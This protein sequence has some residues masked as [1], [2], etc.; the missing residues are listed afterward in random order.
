MAERRRYASTVRAEATRATRRRIL[1]AAKEQFLARGYVGTTLDAVAGAAEV[2]PQT[3]YNVVGGKAKLLKAVY[4]VTLAGDDE[5]VPLVGRP[6]FRRVHDATTAHEALAAYA[7]VGRLVWERVGPLVAVATAQAAAG[8]R[9]LREFVEVI[10]GER[11]TGVQ[12]LVRDLAGRFGLRPGLTVSRATDIVW[13]LFAPEMID[14]L[15]T[16]RGWT[17]PS[18]IEWV[19]ETAV[20]SL[21]DQDMP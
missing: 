1:D 5:P 20:H 12:H 13:V 6:E 2:S 19:T 7:A 21:F 10:Q 18:Y 11:A 14:R 16:Q 8:D 3:V 4:D 9:D 15:V 17:W